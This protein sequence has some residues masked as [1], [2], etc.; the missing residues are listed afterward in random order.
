M[1][2]RPGILYVAAM[3]DKDYVL[4]LP[5]TP[6]RKNLVFFVAKSIALAAD[7]LLVTTHVELDDELL[8][9][10][11]EPGSVFFYVG[12]HR[13]LW[14]TSGVLVPIHKARL[15]LPFVGMGD[16]LIHGRFFQ[17]LSKRV[18]LF[19]IR[20]PSSRGD[21]LESARRLRDDVLAYL[22]RG[23]DVLLFPEGTRTNVAKRHTYGDFF[24]A[25]FEALLEY[26]RNK[27][28]ICAANSG[29]TPREMYIV[30]L[31]VDY[32][33]V[34]EG[35]ELVD[36][37]T[38]R[39]RTLHVFDSL[40]MVRHIGDTFLSYG[41]PIRVADLLQL[42]RKRLAAESR[43]QCME[44]VKILPINVASLAMLRLDASAPFSQVQLEDSIRE[45]V[46]SL[47][48]RADRFRGFSLSD[49]P[50]EIVRRARQRQIGF[51]RL[52]PESIALCRLYA[53]YVRHYLPVPFSGA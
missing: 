41:K 14:E 13:S 39:P 6:A 8:R 40:S 22:A 37:G 34:R 25:A 36:H 35:E 16:N 50:G 3:N 46:A 28:R 30:P 4:P 12:L 20:R 45:V 15:P 27:E 9:I 43:R 48:P 19:L 5:E 7:R 52:D 2:A 24:P 38:R 44:L 23:L 10:R 53:D 42:D 33:Q 32:S 51:E 1:H 26:E 21:M 47:A 29:M 17:G 49:A 31:N 18:G 11:R